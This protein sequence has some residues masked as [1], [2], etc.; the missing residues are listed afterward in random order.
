MGNHN[1][2]LQQNE[3]MRTRNNSNIRNRRQARENAYDQVA[4]GFSLYIVGGASFFKPIKE[5]GPDYFRHSIENHSIHW[6]VI[7]TVWIA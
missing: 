6:I 2:R 7:Y 5:R 3:P 4:I 1:K